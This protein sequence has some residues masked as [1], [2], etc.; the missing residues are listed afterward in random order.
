MVHPTVPFSMM[1][2]FGLMASSLLVSP[3]AWAF[4]QDLSGSKLELS[5]KRAAPH[6]AV[7]ALG[8]ILLIPLVSTV[9]Y[10]DGVFTYLTLPGAEQYSFIHTTML[11]MAAVFLLQSTYYISQCLRCLSQRTEQN[12]GL[13]SQMSDVGTNTLRILILAVAANCLLSILRVLYCWV[14]DENSLFNAL[15]AALQVACLAYVANAALN[16]ALTPNAGLDRE[17]K[18]LFSTPKKRS[19]YQNSGLAE[20]RRR[21]IFL[22]LETLLSV[23]KVYR[24]NRLNL[25]ILCEHLNESPQVV[26]QV[27]NESDYQNFYQMI[28]QCRIEEAKDLLTSRDDL[29]IL[30]IAYLV[31]YNSKSTFNNAF[32][33][34]VMC[35]PSEFRAQPCP[36]SLTV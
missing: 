6:M 35:S 27:I 34:F 17:R 10:K 13:F 19:K 26:S 7:I 15:F 9:F 36:K 33:K 11:L 29:S 5:L 31:G 16:Q 28:N 18:V 22:E 4:A 12:K 25:S 3:C 8:L 24:D 30:D 20:D 2:L 23:Q 1:W 14:L 21:R 32:K